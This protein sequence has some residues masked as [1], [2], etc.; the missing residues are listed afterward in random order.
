MQKLALGR[1]GSQH[2]H[3]LLFENKIQACLYALC[4]YFG[5]GCVAPRE[6]LKKQRSSL[7][8]ED[9]NKVVKMFKISET[10]DAAR[11]FSGR[12]AGAPVTSIPSSPTKDARADFDDKKNISHHINQTN[13]ALA[14]F[15]LQILQALLKT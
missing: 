15:G 11:G 9:S 12:P 14:E 7:M 4:A 2:E 5:L 1:A 8:R 13:I 3:I 10:C 6:R